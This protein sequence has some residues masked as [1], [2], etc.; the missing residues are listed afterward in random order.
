MAVEHSGGVVDTLT[1]DRDLDVEGEGYPEH[2][3]PLLVPRIAPLFGIR[4]VAE[5]SRFRRPRGGGAGTTRLR[6]QA[7]RDG[8]YSAV[9]A[10]LPRAGAAMRWTVGR[11]KQRPV[12]RRGRLDREPHPT[13]TL[14]LDPHRKVGPPN[15]VSDVDMDAAGRVGPG[16]VEAQQARFTQGY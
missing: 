6:R 11:A 8:D 13:P 1:L 12:H 10:E 4:S 3:A 15:V 2:R 7:C 16:P 9:R 14:T 5:A